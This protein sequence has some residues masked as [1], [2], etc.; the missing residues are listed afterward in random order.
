[1]SV[2]DVPTVFIIDDDAGVRDID[3]GFSGVGESAR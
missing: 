2:G 3:P 1:M